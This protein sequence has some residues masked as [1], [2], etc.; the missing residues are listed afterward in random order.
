MN[1]K[2]GLEFVCTA[3][4]GRSPIA[5]AVA[6]DYIKKQNLEDKIVVSSSGTHV[7]KLETMDMPEDYLESNL[8]MGLEHKLYNSSQEKNAK[9]L[10]SKS[11]LP[12]NNKIVKDLAIITEE[13]FTDKEIISRNKTLKNMGLKKYSN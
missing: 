8:K 10:L 12:K 13:Y 3:N 11:N 2:I 9:N 5:Q 1:R 7:N 6:E 4:G